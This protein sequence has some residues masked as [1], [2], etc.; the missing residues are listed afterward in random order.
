[1]ERLLLILTWLFGW[2]EL[3]KELT[4][5]VLKLLPV[6]GTAGGSLVAN[7]SQAC[8]VHLVEQVIQVVTTTCREQL[9]ML[10]LVMLYWG[11]QST[12]LFQSVIPP[13]YA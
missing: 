8:R 2:L 6:L 9:V 11:Q 4:E 7:L 5:A 1:M 10:V 12:A 13:L 3:R